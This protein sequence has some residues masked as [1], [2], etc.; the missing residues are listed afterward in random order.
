MLVF[1]EE[2]AGAIEVGAFEAGGVGE[3]G[4][5]GTVE[6]EEAA[7]AVIEVVRVFDPVARIGGG[8]EFDAGFAGGE[9]GDGCGSKGFAVAGVGPLVAG[10]TE[11]P[12]GRS[13][14]SGFFDAFDGGVDGGAGGAI[15]GEQEER[16][17]QGHALTFMATGSQRTWRFSK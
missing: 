3:G 12:L 7:A 8:G 14:T 1:V 11:K 4:V 5:V 10:G 13:V 9:A 15:R 6:A 17:G 2:A 16:E